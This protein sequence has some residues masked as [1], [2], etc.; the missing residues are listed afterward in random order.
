M[1]SSVTTLAWGGLTISSD[2]VDGANYLTSLV[3]W[4]DLPGVRVDDVARLNAHGSFVTPVYSEPRTVQATG[5][6]LSPAGRDAL[7]QQ[8]QAAMTISGAAAPGTLQVTAVSRTLSAAAQLTKYAPTMLVRGFWQA[9]HFPWVIEWRCPDPRRYSTAL[10][11]SC[12]MVVSGGGLVFP[13]FT[14]TG[15]L[16]FGTVP[17]PQVADFTNTGTAEASI[18]LTVAAGGT[19]LIGGFQIVESQT[20]H[21]I[22]YNDDLPAGSSVTFDSATGL[23]TLNGQADRRSSVSVA[24]WTQA[25]PGA[26]RAFTFQGL[27]TSSA[28]ATLTASM[29][30]AYW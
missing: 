16:G 15:Y 11:D 12:G 1:A 14:G 4:E 29:A 6:S 17:A 9:G 10:V 27:T 22:V 7:F 8:V 2:G 3:G 24:Q 26:Y 5:F 25:A 23:V 30:P 20:G 21:V 18:L 28:T 19:A 13:F